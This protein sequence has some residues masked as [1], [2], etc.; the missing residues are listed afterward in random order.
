MDDPRMPNATRFE[1]D[2]RLQMDNPAS[3]FHAALTRGPV[4]MQ[5]VLT[6]QA[7]L[8]LP[9][10]QAAQGEEHDVD[11]NP[12]RPWGLAEPADM[13]PAAIRQEPRWAR[14]VLNDGPGN[15]LILSAPGNISGWDGEEEEEEEEVL[16]PPPLP[17]NPT[18]TPSMVP[19][20]M[21]PAPEAQLPP[22]PEEEDEQDVLR[23]AS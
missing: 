13:Q 9:D 11:L 17:T 18:P 1:Y 19:A 2:R 23:M 5:S 14:N 20:A 15:V 7:S 4:A 6:N 22:V 8:A 3:N 10:Y 12:V 16:A 21:G